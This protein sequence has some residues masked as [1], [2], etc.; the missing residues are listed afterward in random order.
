[1]LYSILSIVNA[2]YFTKIL[3][4]K[5]KKFHLMMFLILQTCF[6]AH[7]IL[8]VLE[9]LNP[10]SGMKHYSPANF[11]WIIYQAS[12]EIAHTIFAA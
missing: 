9:N 2:A 8:N 3:K 12:D 10:D 7:I 5:E 4:L 1:M 6:S 11:L